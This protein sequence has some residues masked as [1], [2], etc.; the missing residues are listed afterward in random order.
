MT[1]ARPSGRA[2]GD[3]D[4]LADQFLVD[5]VA[6][7]VIGEGPAVDPGEDV[8]EYEPRPRQDPPTAPIPVQSAEQTARP[9]ERKKSWFGRVFG[10]G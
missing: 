9:A 7:S 8:A 2:G 10:G 4:H 6:P 5:G 1:E 3:D